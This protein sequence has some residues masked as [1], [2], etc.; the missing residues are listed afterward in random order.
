MQEFKL[1]LAYDLALRRVSGL[2][3]TLSERI[4]Q[5]SVL[6][7]H[8]RN[9]LDQGLKVPSRLASLLFILKGSQYI[10]GDEINR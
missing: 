10:S 9:A 2:A 1:Q 8:S 6:D 4:L 7:G 3:V 5:A